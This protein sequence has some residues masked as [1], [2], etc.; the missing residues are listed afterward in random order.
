MYTAIQKSILVAVE[1]EGESPHFSLLRM[2]QNTQES[3]Y[4]SIGGGNVDLYK[5]QKTLQFCTFSRKLEL[6]S[7]FFI[8]FRDVFMSKLNIVKTRRTL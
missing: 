2:K 7:Y 5:I 3:M 4:K 8:F 6:W 1:G